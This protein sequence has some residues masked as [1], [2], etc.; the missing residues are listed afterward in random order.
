M[1]DHART[2]WRGR[3]RACGKSLLTTRS[4]ARSHSAGTETWPS[5]PGSVA[6]Y[7]W[8]SSVNPLTGSGAGRLAERPAAA[9]ALGVHVGDRD[10]VGQ[11]G[12]RDDERA[13]VRPRA[14][15][16]GVQV[17][18]AGLGHHG[19][20]QGGG[21]VARATTRPVNRCR[22]RRSAGSRRVRYSPYRVGIGRAR[23]SARVGAGRSGSLIV[24]LW[25]LCQREPVWRRPERAWGAV[26]S[27]VCPQQSRPRRSRGES[28]DGAVLGRRPAWAGRARGRGLPGVSSGSSGSARTEVAADARVVDVAASHGR[29][30]GTAVPSPREPSRH[31]PLQDCG[32]SGSS[33][34]CR[35]SPGREDDDRSSPGAP[36]RGRRVAGQRAGA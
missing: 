12:E 6:S 16:R 22:G 27:A 32:G 14:E 2:R 4:V 29:Y 21:R 11:P 3:R 26:G 15:P 24:L 34:A 7:A 33:H 36:R 23:R 19:A 9:V 5:K 18:P 17:E 20:G 8:R 28:R 13:A 1:V 31:T 10:D 30:A 35:R 25:S